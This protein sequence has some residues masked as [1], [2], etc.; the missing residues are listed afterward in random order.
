MRVYDIIANE[1][2]ALADMLDT[3]TPEQLRRPSLCSGWT[4][5]EVA[6]HLVMPLETGLP[7]LALA[8]VLAR[9]DF[10]K[11]NVKLTSRHAARPVG[12]LA[13]SLRDNAGHR[14][15]P[16][17]MGPEAP[18]TELLVHGQDIRRPLGIDREFGEERMTIALRFL[19]ETKARWFVTPGRLEGL[20]FEA[21][22]LDWSHGAGAT[23]RGPAEALLLAITGRSAALADLKGDGVP[24]LAARL[25]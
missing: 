18:L 3:L 6:A 10:D 7:V 5:R 9:G 20:A 24:V 14:F 13:G 2:R 11:A 12:E 21:T 1:R 15:K 16:P 22:D 25:T 23:V 19:T 17:G 4:V 8:I